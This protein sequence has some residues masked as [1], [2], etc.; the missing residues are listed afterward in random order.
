MKVQKSWNFWKFF[1]RKFIWFY[2]KMKFFFSDFFLF[3]KV[4]GQGSTFMLIT[5]FSG[6]LINWPQ[7]NVLSDWN[8]NVYTYER[9][10]QEFWL[11]A[12]WVVTSGQGGQRDRLARISQA[13]PLTTLFGHHRLS[14]GQGRHYSRKLHMSPPWLVSCNK[15]VICQ[16]ESLQLKTTDRK[17]M[18]ICTI[19]RTPCFS[20]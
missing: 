18:K 7:V 13:A 14:T 4:A 5:S 9:T 8:G 19:F 16:K 2:W 10:P 20:F 11:S 6:G 3:V 1:W 12:S 15:D 17:Q